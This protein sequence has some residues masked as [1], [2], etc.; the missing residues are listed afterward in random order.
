MKT[1][2]KLNAKSTSGILDKIAIIGGGNLGTAIAQGLIK[3]KFSKAQNITITKRNIS[4]LK[5]LENSGV[6]IT[7]N[8]KIAAYYEAN[9]DGPNPELFALKG[10]KNT[11]QKFKPVILIEIVP[12]FIKSFNITVLDFQNY[13]L[14]DLA[15]KIY[16]YNTQTKKMEL[17]SG[18]IIQDRNYIL[19]H[20]DK[21]SQFAHLVN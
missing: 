3:S 5:N 17:L 15:Y 13:I 2:E 19:I 11:L 10:M 4:T 8:N 18:E 14:N 12:L 1:T 9:I 21:I 20:Q 7:S 6:K 16:T